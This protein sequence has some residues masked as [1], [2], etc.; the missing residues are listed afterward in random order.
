MGIGMGLKGACVP[1][2]AAENAPAVIRG[3]LVMSWHAIPFPLEWGPLADDGDAGK[4]GPHSESCLA[5]ARIWPSSMP[6]R[7][8][9]AC[10]LVPRSSPL[11]LS[12]SASTSARSR[13]VG[14]SR[15]GDTRMLTAPS[16]DS[17]TLSSKRLGRLIG[18]YRGPPRAPLTLLAV[19]CT[20]STPSCR[21]RP[22]SLAEATTRPDSSSSSPF[23]VSAEP[24]WQPSRS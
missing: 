9:G 12:P 7:L 16:R 18:S 23:P 14:T 6:E 20:T 21:L 13:P 10:K 3:A 19:T 8:P 1:I 22:P 5:S 4:C 24:P 15:R 11:S 2:F 17:A